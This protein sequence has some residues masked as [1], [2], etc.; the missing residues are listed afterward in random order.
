MV[1]NKDAYLEFVISTGKRAGKTFVLD[2]GEGNDLIDPE[3]G[4]YVEDLSGWLIHKNS[5]DQLMMAKQ[6]GTAYELFSESY[7]FVKWIKN[8]DGSLE[9]KFKKY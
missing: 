3:T 6:Q 9:V 5:K 2:H 7:V 1:L 8:Q 4:W